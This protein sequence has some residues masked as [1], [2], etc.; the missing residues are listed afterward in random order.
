MLLSKEYRLVNQ[1][2]FHFVRI[3][4]LKILFLG[5]TCKG[6]IGTDLNQMDN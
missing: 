5:E 3:Q 1:K 4:Q 2:F 6:P